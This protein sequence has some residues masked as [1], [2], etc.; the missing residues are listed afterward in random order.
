MSDLPPDD[1]PQSPRARRARPKSRSAAARRANRLSSSL[2]TAESAGKEPL[3]QASELTTDL[4]EPEVIEAEE[5]APILRV[6]GLTILSR[7]ILIWATII[8]VA[9][10]AVSIG[11]SL[12]L[13]A[14]GV[15]QQDLDSNPGLEQGLGCL[16][17]LLPLVLPFVGGW[18]ATQ[19][20]GNWKAGGMTGFWSGIIAYVLLLIINFIYG[21][22]TGQ[23]AQFA[24]ID[25]GS[26]LGEVG[27]QLILSFSLGAVGG[28]FS[29]WQ[30]RREQLKREALTTSS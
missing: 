22:V 19:R 21:A 8:G 3:S 5:G 13:T 25:L 30:R 7:Q 15:K 4:S 26:F 2:P 11:P 6:R 27:Y 17:L 24:S 14:F 10:L 9:L 18:R 23:L 29:S 16:F 20:Q 12:I 1:Q 28:W